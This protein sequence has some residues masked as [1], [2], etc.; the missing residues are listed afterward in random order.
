MDFKRGLRNPLKLP[1]INLN[2]NFLNFNSNYGL[3]FDIRAHTL[4]I[5]KKR[6]VLKIYNGNC[7]CYPYTYDIELLQIRK[8]PLWKRNTRFKRNAY[9]RFN[10]NVCLI[11]KQYPS[12]LSVLKKAP[13]KEQSYWKQIVCNYIKTDTDNGVK[14]NSR[15]YNDIQKNNTD[16]GVIYTPRFYTDISYKNLRNEACVS[17]IDLSLKR[18]LKAEK[19]NQTE[20]FSGFKV[21]H[22]GYIRNKIELVIGA[23]KFTEYFDLQQSS[24]RFEEVKTKLENINANKVIRNKNENVSRNHFVNSYLDLN[25]VI[26]DPV[27]KKISI[28]VSKTNLFDEQKTSV[29]KSEI[30]HSKSNKETIKNSATNGDNERNHE[31]INDKKYSIKQHDNLES[32]KLSLDIQE[33][34]T[35]IGNSFKNSIFKKNLVERPKRSFAYDNL[36]IK[37]KSQ[38]IKVTSPTFQDLLL[39]EKKIWRTNVKSD[40]ELFIFKRDLARKIDFISTPNIFLN[41]FENLVKAKTTNIG[42]KTSIS[43]LNA[44]LKASLSKKA[45]ERGGGE[46]RGLPTNIEAIKSDGFDVSLSTNRTLP[47]LRNG[48]N[49]ELF[50][51]IEVN[52]IPNSE[53]L[54]DYSDKVNDSKQKISK[55]PF[56]YAASK[57]LSS[58]NKPRKILKKPNL[59]IKKN[60]KTNS[61]LKKMNKL[62][63]HE[64]PLEPINGLRNSLKNAEGSNDIK[65]RIV[66]RREKKIRFKD[67]SGQGV[68]KTESLSKHSFDSHSINSNQDD[69]IEDSIKSS[70]TNQ[71]KTNS[72]LSNS[73]SICDFMDTPFDITFEISEHSKIS[74]KSSSDSIRNELV[75]LL[76]KDKISNILEIKNSLTNSNS[77]NESANNEINYNNLALKE[78]TNEIQLKSEKL[79]E[80]NSF[81]RCSKFVPLHF[82]RFTNS[83]RLTRA[84]TFSYFSLPK[85]YKKEKTVNSSQKII[86]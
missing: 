60:I 65:I 53:N 6:K 59:K 71:S 50:Q 42:E 44:A 57:F 61:K 86:F 29:F 11:K 56:K 34:S 25:L 36:E 1:I 81:K 55:Y 27:P 72:V 77:M 74:K 12:K 28:L 47:A 22:K 54:S 4:S 23:E 73:N 32:P 69:V 70:R 78:I 51:K 48:E 8:K 3:W 67:Q 14:H 33:H 83:L 46:M 40:T 5:R 82:D 31:K 24:T 49:V 26:V 68:S 15:L 76:A 37:Y 45:N 75:K 35:L 10:S 21:N 30:I 62:Q 80:L 19:E 66:R 84:F 7:I 20:L 64:E 17:K 39:N 58:Q 2:L 38:Q 9:H 85:Q 18:Q 13:F 43:S 16:N 63:I 52:Q 79:N 41:A